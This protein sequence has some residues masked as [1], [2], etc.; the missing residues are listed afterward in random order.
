MN[1]DTF[2]EIIKHVDIHSL[3]KLF[4]TCKAINNYIDLNK[5]DGIELYYSDNITVSN[6]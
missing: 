6:V 1:I 3:G 2:S 5:W 4:I